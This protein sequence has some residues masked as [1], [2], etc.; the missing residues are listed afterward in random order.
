MA[1]IKIYGKLVNATDSGEIAEYSQIA[2]SPIIEQDLATSGFTPVANTYYKHT[3]TTSATYT[4][5]V[6]YLYN[7]SEYKAIDGS[8]SGEGGTIAIPF[9]SID[10]LT[11]NIGKRVVYTG[12][13]KT[14]TALK[15]VKINSNIL[16]IDFNGATFTL[17]GNV[18]LTANLA[19]YFLQGHAHCVIKNLNIKVNYAF[20]SGSAGVYEYNALDV[21]GGMENCLITFRSTGDGDYKIRGV[22]SADHIINTKVDF[23]YDSATLFRPSGVTLIGFGYCNYILWGRVTGYFEYDFG[24]CSYLTNCYS[25]LFNLAILEVNK[26]FRNCTYLTNCYYSYD[27]N[28]Y[29]KSSVG[30]SPLDIINKKDTTGKTTAYV[31]SGGGSGITTIAIGQASAE[32]NSLARRLSDG[33][34]KVGNGTASDDAVN[35]SQLDSVKALK[36]T[37]W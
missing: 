24:E 15:Q 9:T 21:F 33:R 31:K 3:G 35:K 4:K 7:G 8:G 20:S 5:G 13:D 17:S 27:D 29:V 16:E 22:H 6:I 28:L 19:N 32:A 10:D 37:V 12:G 23:D 2:G 11:S 36:V 34:L 1:D 18:S 26:I 30:T 25:R 14:F